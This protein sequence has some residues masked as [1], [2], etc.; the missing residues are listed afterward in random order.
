MG[1][2]L[3]VVFWKD[4]MAIVLSWK[5]HNTKDRTSSKTAI[6][7]TV[8]ELSC[9]VFEEEPPP[10]RSH[11]LD[12]SFNVCEVNFSSVVV[13]IVIAKRKMPLSRSHCFKNAFANRPVI[14]FSS[15][16]CVTYLEDFFFSYT[17]CSTKL[18]K[19]KDL[20]QLLFRRKYHHF[21][22]V[23]LPYSPAFLDGGT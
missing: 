23:S 17:Q 18:T 20:L 14:M 4:F 7:Q 6:F 21:P 11:I 16:H 1:K 2:F 19:A 9:Q 8:G 22:V 5:R 10:L 3:Y 12:Q 15:C 13:R